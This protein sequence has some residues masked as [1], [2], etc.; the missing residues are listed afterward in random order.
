MAATGNK[1]PWFI[2]HS[3]ASL[4]WGGQ[5]LRIIT[6]LTGFRERGARVALIAPPNSKIYKRAQEL[7]IEIIPLQMSKPL[8]PITIT[9]LAL[10]MRRE[11]VQIVNMHSSRDGWIVGLAARLARV[12]LI[13]RSRHFDVPSPNIFMSRITFKYLPHYV[14]TTSRAISESFIRLYGIAENRISDIA[15]GVDTERFSPA[16]PKADLSFVKGPKDRPVI[17]MV[18][19]IRTAKGHQFLLDAV[20][21][22]RREGF[23]GRYLIVGDG[24][25]QPWLERELAAR[26][27]DDCFTLAGFREDIPEILRAI[28]LLL[29]PS[30]HE[31]IPQVGMQALAS[32][33]PFIGSNI[34][35]LPQLI[36]DGIT[37]RT[38]PPSDGAAIKDTILQVFNEPEK[39]EAMVA[40]GRRMVCEEFSIENTLDKVEAIYREFLPAGLRNQGK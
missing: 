40:A 8:Y 16:G 23:E 25:M 21:Q 11:G 10:W 35:G 32:G 27:M 24:P 20:E 9:R 13:I 14:L 28:D 33:T 36:R 5:E 7:K 3:E 12:P 1:T 15:S 31:G 6:E 2:V 22:L 38:F 4:G 29:M 17:A 34:G 26:G 19:V 39:T 18:S 30:L 37:G